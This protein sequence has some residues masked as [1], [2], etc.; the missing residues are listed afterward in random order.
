MRTKKFKWLFLLFSLLIFYFS[1]GFF[2]IQ[3]IGMLP[4]GITIVYFRFGLNTSFI[5]S[6]DGILIAN[7]QKV[8]L[9]GRISVIGTFAEPVAERRI[10]NL[11]YSRILYLVSTRGKEFDDESENEL[12]FQP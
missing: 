2:V 6:P 12:E 1:I 11:P 8:S 7:D 9:F 5:S 4:D 3:P 10:F